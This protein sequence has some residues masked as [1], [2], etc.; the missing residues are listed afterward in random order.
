M[1]IVSEESKIPNRPKRQADIATN[2]TNTDDEDLFN[3]DFD[4]FE[5]NFE[6]AAGAGGVEPDEFEP[7]VDLPLGNYQ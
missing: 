5:L 6:D 1:P 2:H 7:S 3:F 4:N